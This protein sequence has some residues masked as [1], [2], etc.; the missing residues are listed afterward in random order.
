MAEN[1]REVLSLLLRGYVRELVGGGGHELIFEPGKGT[2][3]A[4]DASITTMETTANEVVA[5]LGAAIHHAAASHRLHGGG[6]NL[7]LY[8]DGTNYALRAMSISEDVSKATGYI[9]R[10][11]MPYELLA[12]ATA[13]PPIDVLEME[14]KPMWLTLDSEA[15]RTRALGYAGARMADGSPATIPVTDFSRLVVRIDMGRMRI[16]VE[17][18]DDPVEEVEFSVRPNATATHFSPYRRIDI[19]AH[20]TPWRLRSSP[21]DAY[22]NHERLASVLT[23]A[24]TPLTTTRMRLT[25][26]DIVPSTAPYV[27]YATPLGEAARANVKVTVLD[28]VT[29]ETVAQRTVAGVDLEGEGGETA[30]VGP[31]AFSRRQNTTYQFVARLLPSRCNR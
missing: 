18:R 13:R 8:I 14:L 5:L 24:A 12:G 29:G 17:F 2:L 27:V 30:V 6:A 11:R 20:C 31:I 7:T 1:R 4:V 10:M 21:R 3:V 23:I 26:V 22:L 16:H 25:H 9:R 15:L 28:R 19:D